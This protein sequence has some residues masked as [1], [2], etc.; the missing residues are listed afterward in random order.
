[1]TR[2]HSLAHYMCFALATLQILHFLYDQ[3]I[4]MLMEQFKVKCYFTTTGKL[5]ESGKLQLT[6]SGGWIGEEFNPI[7]KVFGQS[8]WQLNHKAHVD[9]TKIIFLLTRIQMRKV[10]IKMNSNVFIVSAHDTHM[11]KP[12]NIVCQFVLRIPV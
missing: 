7:L 11:H 12:Y 2:T 8:Y 4:S 9:W 3:S 5:H 10:N 1:M 6:V